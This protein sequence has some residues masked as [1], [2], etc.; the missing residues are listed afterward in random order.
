[1]AK[2]IKFIVP[3]PLLISLG[4]VIIGWAKIDAMIAELLSFL[5]QANQSAMYV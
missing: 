4:S 1:M 2:S 5:L 3:D